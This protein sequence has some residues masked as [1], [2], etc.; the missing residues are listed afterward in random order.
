MTVTFKEFHL[1]ESF[2]SALPYKLEEDRPSQGISATATLPN[3]KE[4][5]MSIYVKPFYG[6]TD[7]SS[8]YNFWS[9][10]KFSTATVEVEFNVNGEHRL[11]G[12]G[13]DV[14]LMFG[15]VFKFLKDNLPRM[16]PLFVFFTSSEES[17][18]SLYFKM[19]K[20]S[21]NDGILCTNEAKHFSRIVKSNED[22]MKSKSLQGEFEEYKPIHDLNEAL[23]YMHELHYS[24]KTQPFVLSFDPNI[25]DVFARAEKLIDDLED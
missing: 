17:R 6:Y 22:F 14:F 11:T 9:D 12:N 3:G 20:R 1:S 5:L 13:E 23:K 16:N 25:K 21:F 18:T 7:D 24:G 19:I 15:T 4:L 2:K 8:F 10:K